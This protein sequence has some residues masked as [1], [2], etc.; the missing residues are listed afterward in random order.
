MQAA[1]IA[2]A[3]SAACMLGGRRA[4]FQRGDGPSVLASKAS[5]SQRV[6]RSSERISAEPAQALALQWPFR[7]RTRSVAH[8]SA[9]TRAGVQVTTKEAKQLI[10]TYIKQD[11]SGACSIKPARLPLLLR[12]FESSVEFSG[13]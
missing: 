3:K 2:G 4:T 6:A 7:T 10:E 1:S 11:P 12:D 8:L 5:K 9:A 13:L